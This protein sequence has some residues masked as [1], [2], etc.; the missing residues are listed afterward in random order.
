M[1]LAADT[2]QYFIFSYLVR[3]ALIIIF[4]TYI[5]PILKNLELYLKKFAKWLSAKN[6]KFKHMLK[7]YLKA[8]PS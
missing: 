3:M 1:F 5:D 4:R 2:F 6:P 7:D 8:D